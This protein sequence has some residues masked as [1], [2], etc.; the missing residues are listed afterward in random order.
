MTKSFL[1]C[2]TIMK[3]PFVWEY[4]TNI[5]SNFK[6]H[7]YKEETDKNKSNAKQNKDGR[8]GKRVAIEVRQNIIRAS[9]DLHFVLTY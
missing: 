5:I 4:N 1:G 2:G 6:L 9:P 8:R 3:I 7:V